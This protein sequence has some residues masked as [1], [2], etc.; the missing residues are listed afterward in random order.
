MKCPINKRQIYLLCDGLLDEKE[1]AE[2]EAHL[3][4]CLRCRAVFAEARGILDLIKRP[5]AAGTEVSAATA[6]SIISRA[7]AQNAVKAPVR[8]LRFSFP[9][10]ARCVTA[11][12][13][14]L[15]LVS[16]VFLFRG[17][18]NNGKARPAAAHIL[19]N[20]SSALITTSAK[21]T[22]VW[23]NRMCALRAER[24]S[25]V[26]LVQQTPRVVYFH[27]TQGSILVA[28]HKGLYDTIAV[29]CAA[30]TVFATGTHF[31]VER[32]GTDV[33]V[34]V[35]EGTVRLVDAGT[36]EQMELSCGELCVA[37]DAGTWEKN[38][39]AVS[40]R[41]Q[42][43]FTFE[44]LNPTDFSPS[45]AAADS[46][47]PRKRGFQEHHPEKYGFQHV[48]SHI[49]RGEYDSAIVDIVNY[50]A[51]DTV[52][53]DIA[54]CDLALCY[55]KTERWESAIE[56]YRKAAASTKDSLVAEAIL[57]RTN[58]I[59]F[60]KL[61]RNAEA[62]KGIRE[63]LAKYPLGSWREREYGMLVRIQITQNRSAEARQTV[64]RYEAEFP[65][66][67]SVEEMRLEIAGRGDKCVAHGPK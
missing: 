1:K 32:V 23:F 55:G 50:L 53:R 10:Y 44:T 4:A 59:L 38:P 36:N 27:L 3:K 25:M 5:A 57:H 46:H 16:V 9:S 35:V 56:A 19:E 61:A 40:F 64:D 34:A 33:R 49:R 65:A 31:S 45:L 62:E 51:T 6:E 67:C 15:L 18:R 12:G 47:P 20:P 11:A 14:V 29:Q 8:R 7:L 63:Y 21:D 66:S 37:H 60:S 30:V 39:M 17:I 13:I 24:N 26:S 43:A 48:R 52:D 54:Y 58:S 2:A 22:T 42:L 41:K 28:A